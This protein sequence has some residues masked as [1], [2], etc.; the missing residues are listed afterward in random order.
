M[1]TDEEIILSDSHDEAKSRVSKLNTP[2]KWRTHILLSPPPFTWRQTAAVPL[3][4]V[5]LCPAK[6]NHSVSGL[7]DMPT[8]AGFSYHLST[9]EPKKITEFWSWLLDY[10]EQDGTETAEIWRCLLVW[11]IFSVSCMVTGHTVHVVPRIERSTGHEIT[12]EQSLFWCLQVLSTV[13]KATRYRNMFVR[14]LSFWCEIW[15]PH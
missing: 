6:Q 12:F 3:G 5:F 2:K 1:R 11:W 4:S 10:V 15:L 14:F 13:M 8:S 7:R 9:C